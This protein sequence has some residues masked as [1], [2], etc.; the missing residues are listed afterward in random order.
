M[1]LRSLPLRFGMGSGKSSD[2]FTAYQ[3]TVP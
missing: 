3:F 2:W 1:A